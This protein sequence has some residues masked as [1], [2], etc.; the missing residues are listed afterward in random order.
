LKERE[1]ESICMLR[2]LGGE[3]LNWVAFHPITAFLAW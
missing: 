1:R 3:L 2:V